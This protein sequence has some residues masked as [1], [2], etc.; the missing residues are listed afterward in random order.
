MGTGIQGSVG[1]FVALSTGW[2]DIETLPLRYVCLDK[3][4]R[5]CHHAARNES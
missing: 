3:A 4:G 2:V 5:S 1:M